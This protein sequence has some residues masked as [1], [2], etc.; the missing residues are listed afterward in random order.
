M[1][2]LELIWFGLVPTPLGIGNSNFYLKHLTPGRG[3][4]EVFPMHTCF[5]WV[6]F[7]TGDPKTFEEFPMLTLV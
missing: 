7:A 3:I 2:L 6:H 5:K 4:W 1:I